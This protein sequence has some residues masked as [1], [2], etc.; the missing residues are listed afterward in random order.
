M[1]ASGASRVELALP[2]AA[3]SKLVSAWEMVSPQLLEY[4]AA[5]IRAYV[6]E[7]LT[8][9]IAAQIA[10]EFV[11]ERPVQLEQDL[12][13]TVMCDVTNPRGYS[14]VILP[15]CDGRCRGRAQGSEPGQRG[16]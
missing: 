15:V 8:R 1:R 5:D 9:S 12:V 10:E 6:K 7:S 4:G 13:V 11:K 16:P 14:R 2:V 3:V